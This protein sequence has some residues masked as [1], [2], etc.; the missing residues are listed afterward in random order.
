MKRFLTTALF[1]SIVTMSWAQSP[2]K[3]TCQAVVRDAGDLLVTN[4][5]VGMQISIL[6]TS[7]GGISVYIET[8][9][10]ISNVIWTGN[11]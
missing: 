3:M 6:Q 2:Q 5:A 4:S 9:T 11:S 10:P 8:H 1:L 7:P